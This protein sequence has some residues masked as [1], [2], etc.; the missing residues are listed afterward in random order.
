MSVQR[1]CPQCDR[2]FQEGEAV[3][4]CDGCGVLHHPG[5]WVTNG[6]CATQTEHHVS[7]S[8]MAYS[9]NER[10]VGSAAPHPGEGTRVAP[11]PAQAAEPLPEPIPFR[12]TRPPVAAAVGDDGPVIGAT[13]PAPMI[14]RTLPST[15]GTPPMPRRYQP[16]PGDHMQR[17]AMPQIYDRHPIFTYWYVPVAALVAIFVAFS[18]IWAVGKLT[19]GDSDK[20]ADPTPASTSVPG[21]G[22]ATAQPTASVTASVPATVS[23]AASTGPGKFKANDAVVVEGTGDCLNVRVKAGRDNDAIV[24]VKDGTELRVTGGPELASELTWWK[25]KTELGE[26]WAAEDYLTKKP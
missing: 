13:A 12:P 3:L 1:F 5:C 11:T 18:V 8:A 16:P 26:G 24:C 10:T 20:A 2:S 17:K 4:R 21:G 15:A 19:G 14:H 6:G 22:I 9:A 25:V 7:P 23:A